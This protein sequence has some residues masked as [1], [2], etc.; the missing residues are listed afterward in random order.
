MSGFYRIGNPG[1][2]TVAHINTG[3]RPSGARCAM[4]RFEKDSPQWGDLCGRIS[5]ALCDAPQCD[6]PMCELHRTRHKSKPDTDFCPAH[7]AM[8]EAEFI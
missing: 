4:P 3:R 7:K 6:L 5:V 2:D 1:E 8:A